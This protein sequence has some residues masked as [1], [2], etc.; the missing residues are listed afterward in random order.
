MI[1]NVIF[2][3][4]LACG[5]TIGLVVLM[6][7]AT[8]V[9][10]TYERQMLA[11]QMRPLWADVPADSAPRPI[12]HLLDAV[13]ASEPDF[14]PLSVQLSA[15]PRAPAVINGGRGGL[16]Y[17]NR[18]TAE[19]LE[20]P[21]DARAAFFATVTSWHRWFNASP[22]SRGPWRA[23]TGVSNLAFLFLILSGLYLWLPRVFRWPLFRSHLFFNRHALRGKARDYNWH[24]VF[25]FWTA[26]PLAIVV[27]TAVVFS[28]PWANG[29]VYRVF[30]EDVPQGP[31]GPPPTA[32]GPPAGGALALPAT[33]ALPESPT[34]SL[35]ALFA[36]AAGRLP[37]WQTITLNLPR[38]GS[39]TVSFAIDQGNG[40]QPQRRHTLTLSATT[41]EVDSWQPFDSQSPGRRARIWIR[42]LH[43][44][45][46]LGI[47]GQ[48]VA[49]IVSLTSVI[50]VWTGLALAWRRLIVPLFRR[51]SSGNA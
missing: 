17:L 7:S 18:Y 11:M 29:A 3:S 45:E 22:D 21:S 47:V 46:A 49:G 25:G 26:V 37:N 40:G 16:R 35:D 27:A 20:A 48:T 23:V 33:A 10:L 38:P 42:F 30:G 28:F 6:M 15:N 8:G 31:G 2:W 43:T 51:P 41:G 9:L 44:G 24:H 1:R 12:D 36:L 32:G 14:T 13:R 34:R 50:M 5:V 4:H 19:V 39:S